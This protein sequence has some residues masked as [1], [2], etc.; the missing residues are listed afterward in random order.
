VLLFYH[1]A[2]WW[3]N[4]RIRT[5]RELC[6]D[7]IAVTLAGNRFEYARALTLVA[8]WATAPRL[9]MALG[10]GSLSER[11]FHIMARKPLSTRPRV[12]GL[13]GSILF[14]AA[15]LGAANALFGIAY[16]IPAAHAKESV[17][18][19][20]SSGQTAVGHMVRQA[21]EA[22]APAAKGAAPEQ[23]SHGDATVDETAA[24]DQIKAAVNSQPENPA[25]L[26]S[27]LLAASDAPAAAQP[28]SVTPAA[29][30]PVPSGAPESITVTAT[31]LP[32]R[33][34]VDEFIYSYPTAVR[35]TDKIARWKVGI[36][37]MV[38]GL[39]QHF[40]DFISRRLIAIAHKAGA[41]VNADPKCRHNIQIVF[42]TKP[43][44]LADDVH[45]NHRP[46]LGYFDNLYQADDPA[47]SGSTIL[48]PIFSPPAP[49]AEGMSFTPPAPAVS[50]AV[51][52][53][54]CTMSSSSPIPASWGITRWDHSPTISPCWR[55]PS[56]RASMPAGKCPASPIFSP[57]IARLPARPRPSATMTSPFST[58][59][60][61]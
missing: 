10:R 25:P 44:A 17:K 5:E 49:M 9:A 30:P 58:G 4:R 33:P 46:Y 3:L 47:R 11:I 43:Q 14:L 51:P 16:P 40:A 21:L 55:C 60:T 20:L 8:E 18:A 56:P 54:P 26:P 45:K 42:T 19:V 61:R 32:G 6:C 1:P 28:A 48:E 36:C 53:A 12:L 52:A 22:T 41:P 29:A 2:L 38:A 37:P 50:T 39:P 13:T 27:L 35:T 7:E 59:S 23:P 15:A 57:R 24:V 31:P 34:A